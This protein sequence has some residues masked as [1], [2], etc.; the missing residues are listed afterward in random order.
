MSYIILMA[1]QTRGGEGLTRRFLGGA[2]MGR[3]LMFLPRIIPLLFGL[4]FVAPLIA[5]TIGRL[6]PDLAH[7]AWP[8]LAGLAIGGAWGAIANI[9]GRWI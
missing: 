7:E 4:G 5:Q 9:R 1:S 6:R 3:L 8:T 2:R